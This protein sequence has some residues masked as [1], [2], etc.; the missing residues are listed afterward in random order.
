MSGRIFIIVLIS[1]CFSWSVQAQDIHFSQY[2]S[3]PLTLNPA[4]TGAFNAD[5]RAAANFRDQYFKSDFGVAPGTY[6]TFSGSFDAALFR[7]KLKEDGLGVGVMFFNDRAGSGALTTQ[8]VMASI[9]YHKTVDKYARHSITLGINVGFFQKRIDFTKLTFESQ[10]DGDSGFDPSF[11]SGENVQN[12]SIIAPDVGVGVLWR[13]RIGKKALAYVGGSYAHITQPNESFIGDNDNRLDAKI[14]IHG[15]VD[16]K[17]GKYL[18]LIPAFMVLSQGTAFQANPGMALGYQI[19]DVSNFY[20]G[21]WYRIGDAVIPYVGYDIY[22]MRIGFSF[23][24]T[25]SNLKVANNA[26]GAVELSV[27]YVHGQEPPRNI[28]PVHFCPKF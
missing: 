11:G 4:L 2:F 9:A 19:N 5:F 12:N 26:R 25:T 20:I 17:V 1:C 15:G 6:M 21:S 7:K 24:A 3:S 23:D 16:V 13:S 18:T 10:F 28:S 22:N 27:V 8:S 14:T